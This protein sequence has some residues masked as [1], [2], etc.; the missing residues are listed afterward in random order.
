MDVAG[1]YL[2][3]V[4][5]YLRA[6]GYAE[7]QGCMCRICDEWV[8]NADEPAFDL[9]PT[10]ECHTQPVHVWCQFL[11]SNG[12]AVEDIRAMAVEEVDPVF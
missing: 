10:G 9:T 4:E 6:E 5:A 1:R 2:E 11:E 8:E 7:A 3:S 12:H